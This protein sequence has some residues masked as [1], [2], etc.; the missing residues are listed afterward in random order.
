M[1]ST[2]SDSK[3]DVDS[4]KGEVSHSRELCEDHHGSQTD[5]IDAGFEPAF[6]HRTMRKVDMRLVPILAALYAISLIDRTN[7]G[8]ARAANGFQMDRD[9][10]TGEGMHY[11]IATMLFFVPYIIFEVPVRDPSAGCVLTTVATWFAQVW[12]QDLARYRNRAVGH[13][14]HWN[15]VGT[16][17]AGLGRSSRRS[18]PVR[19]NTVPRC[20][21]PHRDMVPAAADGIAQRTILPHGRN[22]VSALQPYRLLLYTDERP[23]GAQWLAL[24]VYPVRRHHRRDRYRRN[25]CSSRLPR[26]GQVPLSG[27]ARARQGAH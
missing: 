23:A 11:S 24:G 8:L 22:H 4:E 15:G 20:D 26:Q 12:S 21:L 14:D 2:L 27:A 10:G 7:L 25:R 13:H 1:T 19:G 3:H 16:L 18:R 9:I 5:N 17:V 6:V